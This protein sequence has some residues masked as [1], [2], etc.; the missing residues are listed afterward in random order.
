MPKQRAGQCTH[1]STCSSK[2]LRSIHFVIYGLA[3][4]QRSHVF[5]VNKQF[6]FAGFP[7]FA[8]FH[9]YGSLSQ[10][11]YTFNL[12]PLLNHMDVMFKLSFILSLVSGHLM[13]AGSI[14]THTSHTAT[15]SVLLSAPLCA[16]ASG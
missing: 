2:P 11:T 1:I 13:N 3:P 10:N 7:L 16:H 14:I 15:S 9:H 8:S 4:N 5:L 12:K 6:P